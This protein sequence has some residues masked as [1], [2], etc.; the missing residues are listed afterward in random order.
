MTK[1][2]VH[3][4]PHNNGWAVKS[5]GASKAKSVHSTQQQAIDA[6]RDTAK[7]RRSEILIHGKNGQIRE[8]DSYGNDPFPPH[9]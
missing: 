2:N 5:A 9:G 3:V 4:V 6:G 8:R 1:K 7:A